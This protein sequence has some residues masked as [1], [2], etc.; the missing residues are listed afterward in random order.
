MACLVRQ[1]SAVGLYIQQPAGRFV[2]AGIA[3]LGR[4]VIL[5][6]REVQ[7][8]VLHNVLQILHRDCRVSGLLEQA[9]RK[10]SMVVISQ[11]QVLGEATVPSNFK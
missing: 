1:P 9:Q 8:P 2:W 3:R 10:N 11:H 4:A 5:K 6:S 7:E